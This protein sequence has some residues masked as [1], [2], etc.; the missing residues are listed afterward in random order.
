M[1]QRYIDGSLKS[2]VAVNLTTL[3]ATAVGAMLG[4]SIANAPVIGAFVGSTIGL[5]IVCKLIFAAAKASAAPSSSSAT[6]QEE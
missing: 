5:A 1:S 2:A 4:I 3:T 6:Q